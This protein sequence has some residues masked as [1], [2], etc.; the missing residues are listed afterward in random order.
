MLNHLK[1]FSVLQYKVKQLELQLAES[2]GRE[3][4]LLDIVEN[5]SLALPKPET[6]KKG[7]FGKLFGGE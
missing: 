5:T 7:F 2:K 1:I 6:T 4:K 3:T